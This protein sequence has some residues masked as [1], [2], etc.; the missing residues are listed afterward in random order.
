MTDTDTETLDLKSLGNDA[1]AAMLRQ[2]PCLLKSSW[3]SAMAAIRLLP[4]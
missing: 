3:P 4:V 2:S 1:T